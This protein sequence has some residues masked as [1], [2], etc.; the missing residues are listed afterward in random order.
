MTPEEERKLFIE[1]LYALARFLEERPSLP[2]GYVT[3]N[4]FCN[5]KA[6][7]LSLARDFGSANKGSV[8]DYFYLRKT[9]K[10][11]LVQYDLNIQRAAVCTKKT[12]TRIVP[13]QPERTLPAEPEKT[14][15]VVEWECPDSIFANAEAS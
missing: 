13:A 2:V 6:E 7:F 8:A 9:F 14:E 3:V 10:S 15:E 4:G 11:G 5:G 1:D 12:T